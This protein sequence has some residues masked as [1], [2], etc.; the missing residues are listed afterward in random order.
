MI[1]SD[2]G[3]SE[4][5]L[6]SSDLG[7]GETSSSN[8]IVLLKMGSGISELFGRDTRGFGSETGVSEG[9]SHQSESLEVG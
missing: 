3:L 7:E 6:D 5:S 4:G 2:C 8:W 1:G 9:A